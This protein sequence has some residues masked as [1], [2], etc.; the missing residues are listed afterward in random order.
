MLAKKT[1]LIV[2]DEEPILQAL[3]RILELSGNY[4]A[5]V[6]NDGQKALSV[7]ESTVPDL[8]ISD[9]SMPGM[10]GLEFCQKVRENPVTKS[11]PFIFLTAKKEKMVE[12]IQAGGDDFLIKPFN[13]D[14][15][16]AKIEAI[17]RRLD[18]TREQA[19]QHKGKIEDT[20][21]DDVLQ[22]CLKERISG[23]LILQKEGQ[24]GR[25]RLENGD[26]GHVEYGD[27][28]AGEA[29]D[30]LRA[31]RS[32]TWVIRPSDLKIKMDQQSFSSQND[33]SQAQKLGQNV[34]WTGYFNDEANVIYNSYL[35][36]FEGKDSRIH[37]LIDPGSP[38]HFNHIAEKV[39]GLI[40]DIAKISLYLC[41]EP[42]PDV[43]LNSVLLRRANGRAIC[44]TSG[45][46][47][48]IIRHY[49]INPKSLKLLNPS[50]NHKI[51]MAS[52]QQLMFIETPYL[53]SAGA[54]MTYDIDE[55]IL[56]SGTLFSSEQMAGSSLYAGKYDWEGMR[57]FHQRYVSSSRAIELAINVI[58]RLNPAP[59]IIA[60][61][62]GKLITSS[63][64]EFFS[65]RLLNLAVGLDKKNALTQ[66]GGN[67]A[68]GEAVN[69]LLSQLQDMMSLEQSY[70]RIL[71]DV[72]LS[73]SMAFENYKTTEMVGDGTQLFAR[74]VSVLC[75]EQS[76]KNAA[77]IR[78]LA[79][80]TAFSKGLTV[81][82][83]EASA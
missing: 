79:L 22:V 27:M 74:L 14:E 4:Q 29:L 2:E 39:N 58:S 28:D 16:L 3:Q 34:W 48:R 70:E 44:M 57:Q 33:L 19:S 82:E 52:G 78:S 1:I 69:E 18:N 31:W 35:R 37:L 41:G 64:I 65:E 40:G 76:E 47:W 50:Q 61:R 60:P 38:I 72:K 42:E 51:R 12:G 63:Y 21:V 54:F 26:I 56:F 83:L 30:A 7:L 32:G 73:A 75:K 67:G 5:L 25:I 66:F 80:K 71:A 9:I 81:P 23:D 15:V 45:E 20:S 46:N 62:M 10:S 24:V 13:V 36:S 6:A 53:K 11:L 77:R 49:E 17:F 43:C 59:R 8:I 68:A 55:R